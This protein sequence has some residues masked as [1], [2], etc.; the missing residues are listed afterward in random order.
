MHVAIG[1]HYDYN[2]YDGEGS[3]H[4]T[5]QSKEIICIFSMSETELLVFIL[6]L[7]LFLNLI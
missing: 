5:L 7:R 3:L 4:A 6:G 1:N 2:E